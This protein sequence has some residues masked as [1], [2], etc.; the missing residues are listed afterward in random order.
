[1][2]YYIIIITVK[3]LQNVT[4]YCFCILSKCCAKYFAQS[5]CSVNNIDNR[6]FLLTFI[7]DVQSPI[8]EKDNPYSW[9]G[10]WGNLNKIPTDRNRFWYLLWFCLLLLLFI[11]IHFTDEVLH[12]IQYVWIMCCIAFLKSKEFWI[13][14]PMRLLKGVQMGHYE[15]RDMDEFVHYNAVLLSPSSCCRS[16]LK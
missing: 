11:L 15:W 4:F 5:K 12:N 6:H 16:P 2:K 14:K 13:V 7:I 9:I 3:H 1:M 8:N 10:K